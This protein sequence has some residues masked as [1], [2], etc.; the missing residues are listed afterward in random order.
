[1]LRLLEVRE[2]RGDEIALTLETTKGEVTIWGD[3]VPGKGLKIGYM[4]SEEF[5]AWTDAEIADH[6]TK[7]YH[8]DGNNSETWYLSLDNL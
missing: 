6:I 7:V 3:T 2:G 1:M 4:H 5:Q 8:N